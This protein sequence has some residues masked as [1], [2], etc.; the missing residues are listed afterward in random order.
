MTDLEF[1]QK[2]IQGDKR[3]WDSFVDK[4][5]G[6][7]YAYIH[8]VFKR[9]S[10]QIPP[11]EHISD[12]FQNL[13]VSLTKDDFKKI[14]TFQARNGCS[15]ASWLRIVTVNFTLDY[16]R[17]I[18]PMASLDARTNDE[19]PLGDLIAD[20]ADSAK[21]VAAINEKLVQL[22]ECIERLDLD[23]RL[24][25]ELYLSGGIN[26]ESLRQMLKLSRGAVDMRKSR[27]IERLKD[28]FRLKG[29]E[30]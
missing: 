13:F 14:R 22:E 27:I 19:Q 17:K 20:P 28:C 1:V 21:D 12:I 2:C 10:L 24:F 9:S 18:R 8:S 4:Y 3:S 26:L 6:L 15:L 11:Q 30:M 23:S 25:M 16:L 5:S 29:F 7:I